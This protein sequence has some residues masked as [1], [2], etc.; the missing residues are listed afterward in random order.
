MDN[1][2][3]KIKIPATDG[4]HLAATV[5]GS[6]QK[7]VIVNPA[8]A[9]PQGLYRRFATFLMTHGFRVITYDYRGIADS[10]PD[11]LR[12]F[13]ATFSEW[14]LLDMQGVLDWVW[15]EY[16]PTSLVM[17]GHSAGGQLL[18]MLKGNERID[19]AVTMSSQSGYW[20]LQGGNQPLIV[21]FQVTVLM[22]LIA[23]TFGYFP[24]SK[25]G[26]AEDLPLGAALEW[27]R[28]C[29]DPQYLLGDDSLP[30]D[31]YQQFKVPIL[32]YSVD[33]DDWGT[34]KSVRAMMSAYP[35]VSFEHIVPFD[36]DIDSLGH[37]GYFKRKSERIWHNTLAWINQHVG[38]VQM[39][40][41]A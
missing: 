17:V 8:T 24:W 25:L 1:Q 12:G 10:A 26:S 27:C 19:T 21:R 23:R 13:Q 20:G 4:Y 15:A 38:D 5:Y 31:R 40:Q 9:V 39:S 36:Y 22:P 18:G 35:N 14:G 37:M 2:I 28:W 7:V 11:S 6:G 16:E 30:L 41:P 32:A 34:A 33:D 29:R 3:L